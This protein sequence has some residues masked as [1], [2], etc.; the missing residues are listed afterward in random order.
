[1]NKKDWKLIL[2]NGNVYDI[3]VLKTKIVLRKSSGGKRA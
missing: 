2:R 1:M 3:I